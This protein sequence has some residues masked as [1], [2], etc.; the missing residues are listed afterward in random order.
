M[1]HSMITGFV[2][3]IANT[4]MTN[5]MARPNTINDFLGQYDLQNQHVDGTFCFDGLE[6]IQEE[7]RLSVYRSDMAQA[8]VYSAEV[9]G[10]ARVVKGSHGEAMSSYSGTEA[11][12]F[13][14]NTL[15]FKFEAVNKIMG[16]PM[17][18]ESDEI[19]LVI[20]NDKSTLG[21]RRKTFEGPVAGIGSR[22]RA[23]CTYQRR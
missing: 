12:V 7:N 11:A 14:E 20:S 4:V 8:P 16:V 9:N 19:S 18:R 10:P 17:T 15:F 22:A 21:L 13:K 23:E 2:F 1:K 5:A 3:L 6:I